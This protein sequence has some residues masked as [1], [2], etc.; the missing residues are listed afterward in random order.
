VGS[1][2]ILIESVQ[3]LFHP[4]PTH[5]KGMMLFAILGI[6]VNGIAALRLRNGNS[7]NQKM[8]S[9]H[10]IEDVLGWVAVLIVSIVLMFK[11]IYILDPILSIL[12]SAYVHF[13]A[14]RNLKSVIKVLMQGV[15]E[16][17]SIDEIERKIKAIDSV[18]SSHHT[19]VWSF[20]G[21]NHVLTTHVV[22]SD[23]IDSEKIV[24]IKNKVREINDE[25]G[26]FHYT[27]EI[28]RENEDC[29]MKQ[30]KD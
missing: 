11:D 29:G 18:L 6:I 3:R 10:L 8:V 16:E 24:S 28:E 19:H 4:E 2:F 5:A 7:L 26:I 25:S 22:V 17:I 20:D 21:I 15:P 13:N 14:L 9:W 12:I 27:I 23:N 30:E 1:L